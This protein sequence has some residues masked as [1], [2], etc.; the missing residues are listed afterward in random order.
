FVGGH[1]MA[2]SE[3]SGFEASSAAL[4]RARPWILTPAGSTA[5]A[6]T[7]V[8]RMVRAAGAR[9]TVMSPEEHDRVV[10]CLSH[11]PQL[12]AGAPR[13]AALADEVASRHLAMAGPAFAEMTR[14]ARS[15]VEL[16]RKILM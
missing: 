11:R 16:W 10:A 5:G 12:A 14:L 4:F 9:P 3:R 6:V 13:A 8:R 1:P 7:K 15:P 2:G